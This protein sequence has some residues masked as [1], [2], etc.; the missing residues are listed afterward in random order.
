MDAQGG[1]EASNLTREKILAALGAL[2]N[3]LG[4]RGITGEICLFR[5]TVMVLAFTARLAT[6]DVDAVFQPT[7][8]I[9]EIA[10][11]V[12]EQLHLPST[13]LND[14]V[15]G[16]VSARHETTTGNLPQFHYLRLTRVQDAYLAATAEHLAAA[17]HLPIP[18]WVVDDARKL[19]RPWF[20]SQ[21]ASLRAVLLLESP[22]TFRSR[23][24]F[25]SENALTRV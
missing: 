21:L 25:V 18:D 3:Q 7:Q 17:H 14:G 5:G 8:T 4:E 10:R 15:K 13:W 22:P 16:Y 12:G 2:S 9:R 1:N 24:L 19:H 20:A 11:K 23:N 6:K